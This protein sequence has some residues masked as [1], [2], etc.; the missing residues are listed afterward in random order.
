MKSFISPN[1]SKYLKQVEE[2]LVQQEQLLTTEDKV[3]HPF[4]KRAI[5]AA[6]QVYHANRIKVSSLT[7]IC[8]DKGYS[9]TVNNESVSF[10]KESDIPV[11]S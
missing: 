4:W 9:L 2:T 7:F 3:T 10:L 8:I 6:I 5:N 11:P 1:A